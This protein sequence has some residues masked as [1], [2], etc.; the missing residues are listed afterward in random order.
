MN[1]MNKWISL[2]VAGCVGGLITVG[3]VK[4]LDI[5][6][7][8]EVVL[9]VS[10]TTPTFALAKNISAGNALELDFSAVAEKVTPAVV[11]IMAKVEMRA[12][13]S[14]QMIDPFRE[15]F[16]DRF[17][18][19]PL[20]PDRGLQEKYATS[21]GSG[22]IISKDGYIVT[23]NHVVAGAKELEVTLIDKR[24]YK[25]KVIGTDPST[26]L[27][28]IQI[29]ENN[30]PTLPFGNS[31]L[32]KVG[33]WVLAVGNPYNLSSTVTAGVVSAKGRNLRIVKDQSPIESFIQ[34]DAAINPGNS[35]G[36]LVNVAGELIGINTAI[37]S[38]TGSFSGYGFAVP[39]NLVMK[40][41]E[42]IIKYGAVQR[43][44]LGIFISDLDSKKADAKDID[45]IPGIYVDSLMS[46]SAAKD[47]GI[48]KG[49][50]IVKVDG[51]EVK[52]VGELQE[53]I[54]RH[55][56]G[57]V[58]NLTINRNGK[59]QVIPVTLKNK[60][61]KT[62]VI[63]KEDRE[64]TALL[65]AEFEDLNDKDRKKAAVEYGVKVKKVY[66]GGKLNIQSDIEEGFIITK[67][68]K[69]P[70]KSVKELKKMLQN[71]QGGVMIEG[72]YP[73]DPDVRYFALGL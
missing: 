59:E 32:T 53:R 60:D 21:T 1:S 49:D 43:G 72:V 27:A 35:G 2:I 7:S 69:Q 54:G 8:K 13:V 45:F 36:A 15:F 6:Q 37:S 16:G 18:G 31:D 3:A 17:F 56:P 63:K 66:P 23:N 14:P 26:D 50:V 25:A 24:S 55:R 19:Q 51:K 33:A 38:P 20:Q 44:Y 11:S 22:V 70:V 64:I 61:G 4:I 58:V 5:N 52:N 71:K 62:E 10:D 46:E 9:Q 40:V 57:E 29:R 48:K 65:G 28:V 30:L 34:T 67:I 41:V 42:D 12:G 68:D 39:S 73:G 47:A